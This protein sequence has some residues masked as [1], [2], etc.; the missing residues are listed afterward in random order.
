LDPEG[1]PVDV[2]LEWWLIAQQYD[3]LID[4]DGDE[5]KNAMD[6]VMRDRGYSERQ[7][8]KMLSLYGKKRRQR[9]PRR[10]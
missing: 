2:R 10:R 9:A 1:T 5:P 6:K 7:I 3:G 8:R 4:D